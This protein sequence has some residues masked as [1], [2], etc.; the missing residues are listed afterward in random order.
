V[1]P[2]LAEVIVML[3][4]KKH[5]QLAIYLQRVESYVFIDDIARALFDTGILPATIHD[6]VLVKR[7]H[8]QKAIEIISSVF[9]RHFGIVPT[10]EMEYLGTDAT[11]ACTNAM[12]DS[13][14]W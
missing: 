7:E 6:S 13:L 2:F 3:K 5:N 12:V 11:D 8:E 9:M 10:L 14:S 1:C 4:K